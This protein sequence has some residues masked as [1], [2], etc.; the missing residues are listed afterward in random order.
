MQP[1]A[2]DR[3]ARLRGADL[4]AL[5][6]SDRNR[7]V[8]LVRVGALLVVVLGHWVMQGLWITD[9]GVLRRTG[10]LST[11]VWAHPF[12]WVLQVVPI[13]FLVGGYVNAL[14]WRRG[15][16]R[17]IGY[18]DWL[19][20]RTAR[21]VRPLLPLL[22][23][24]L[25]AAPG[26]AHLG[27]GVDWLRIAGKAS[28][29]PTWFLAVYLVVVSLTPLTLAWW[30]RAGL[31]SVL[32]GVLL[33]GLVD[34]VSL[35]LGGDLG[36][37]VG[38]LNMLVVWACLHQLGYA[39]R[40]GAAGG[41]AHRA[42]AWLL[43]LG[44]LASAVLLVRLGPYGVSMVGV[45]GYGVDNS[46]PPRVTLLLVGLAQVGAVL[47]LEPGLARVAAR[48]AV[49]RATALVGSRMMTIYLWHLTAFGLLA[50]GCLWLGG[51]GMTAEPATAA[52]W[53]SRPA[54]FLLLG[55]TT[56]LLVLLLG[57]LEPV[58]SRVAGAAG[59]A[60]AGPLLEVLTACVVIWMLA[61]HGVVGAD[62]EPVWA[63]Q[64][65][66]LLVLGVLTLGPVSSGR[67]LR[68]GRRSGG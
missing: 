40:D 60:A 23:F 50:A 38:A 16:E 28:L 2:R 8:D 55:V 27:L 33:A 35:R 65:L 49:W 63:W 17:G 26:A 6:P 36:L 61:R 53:W 34:L 3:P 44:A 13:F 58:G 20:A 4:E 51:A 9:E 31:G 21:L 54:W 45:T 7:V 1:T 47:V 24:W 64:A 52:W 14:S 11:Q 57:R 66:G 22:A 18:G 48:P 41:S 29:V 25:V 19:A 39:W 32:A 30:E 10:M 59:R 46:I 67:R 56:A 5:T 37:A 12:T 62:G 42:R 43:L 68:P 15:R